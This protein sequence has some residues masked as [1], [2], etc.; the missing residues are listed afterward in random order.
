MSDRRENIAT[1]E[2]TGAQVLEVEVVY[3]KG[4]MNYFTYESD[5]RGFYLHVT[6]VEYEESG[7]PGI[8][9][10]KYTLF[11]GVK[12]FV[13]PT[14]RFSRKGLETAVSLAQ[15]HVAAMVEHVLTENNLTRAEAA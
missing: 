12:K 11:S 6:P 3:S 9:W 13:H 14:K 7:T 10:K 2:T 1:I 8:R 4:G 5:P 15:E